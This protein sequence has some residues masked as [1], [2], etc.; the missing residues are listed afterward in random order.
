MIKPHV[1]YLCDKLFANDP[2]FTEII[3]DLQETDDE[4]LK[5]IFEAAKANKHVKKTCFGDGTLSE[6]AALSPASALQEC[7]GMQYN[8]K[9]CDV[10]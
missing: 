8:F 7:H 6:R 3:I 4:D 2:S 9:A 1:Q 5:L 10:V